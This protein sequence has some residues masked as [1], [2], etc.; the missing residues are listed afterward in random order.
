MEYPVFA[1]PERYLQKR[2]GRFPIKTWLKRWY[3]RRALNK[4]LDRARDV[5]SICDIPCGPGRLFDAWKPRVKFVQGVDLS[6]DM[7]HAAKS[8]HASL[9]LEGGVRRGNAFEPEDLPDVDMTCSVRF[10]YYFEPHKRIEL[11][12]SLASRAGKYLIVQYKSLETRKGRRNAARI[13]R[14]NDA[15]RKHFATHD[16]IRDEVI[17]A[18]LEFLGLYPIAQ[19]SDRVFVLARVS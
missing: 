10:A 12:R 11:L 18:G 15:Y 16:Q 9:G 1:E 6:D 17:E 4:C 8:E 2:E 7:L 5:Q 19:S 13:P 14:N 3:E